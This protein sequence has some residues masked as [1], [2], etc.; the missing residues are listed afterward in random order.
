MK[1][2]FSLFTILAMFWGADAAAQ[3]VLTGATVRPVVE[4][5]V[6]PVVK[7]RGS[8]VTSVKSLESSTHRGIS[9]LRR[10]K[11][12][13][14]VRC[15]TNL[16]LKCYAYRED[17]MWHGIDAD[18]C[19]AIALAVVGDADHIE[20]VNVE[21]NEVAKALKTG[22]IDVMLSGASVTGVK[23]GKSAF[24]SMGYKC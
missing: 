21:A 12:R 19:K 13:D 17:E 24:T 7:V 5:V 1:V 16:Q 6:Q 23:D 3:K 20:M 2:F 9:T 4:P 14:R 18:F 8:A 11:Q 22:K 10:I 15:G